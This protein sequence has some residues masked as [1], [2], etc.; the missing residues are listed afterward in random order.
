MRLYAVV[1]IHRNFG[2]DRRAVGRSITVGKMIF[3][4]VVCLGCAGGLSREFVWRQLVWLGLCQLRRLR[5][6]V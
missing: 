2:G 1:L 3:N 4:I 5:M 6:L